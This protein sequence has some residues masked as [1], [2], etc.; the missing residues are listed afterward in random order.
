MMT[1][2]I[3]TTERRRLF[4]AP[5]QDIP[6]KMEPEAIHPLDYRYGDEEVKRALSQS[7]KFRLMVM[8]EGRVAEVQSELG[9]IPDWAGRGIAE[10]ARRGISI[11]KIRER[12]KETAHETAAVISCL[13]EA[14]G[15]AGRFVHFGL[16]SNDVLDTAMFLQISRA[17]DRLLE[18]V[19]ALGRALA[20]RA[21]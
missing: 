12:E 14:A 8:I 16:T 17:G 6:T 9:V 10:A 15:K 20:R 11:E 5:L 13:E 4:N 18:L 7:E 19:R 21:E 2:L 1:R 3:G